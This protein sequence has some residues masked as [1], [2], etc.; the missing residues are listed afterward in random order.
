M[1]CCGQPAGCGMLVAGGFC[2][3]RL[4][5]ESCIARESQNSPDSLWGRVF[6]LPPPTGSSASGA[7]GEIAVNVC[8]TTSKRP[9]DTS[10]SW[11]KSSCAISLSG[12]GSK[13]ATPS[14]SEPSEARPTPKFFRTL[15]RVLDVFRAYLAASYSHGSRY[16][17][18]EFRAQLHP[19]SV[20]SLVS[21]AHIA[22]RTLLGR[23]S[24]AVRPVATSF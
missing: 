18:F 16:G 24:F 6:N 14:E 5:D 3:I 17:N 4:M 7:G 23:S 11:L 21:L 22:C 10:G 12:S 20:D 19:P 9:A 13:T 15:S 1:A 8:L 2:S